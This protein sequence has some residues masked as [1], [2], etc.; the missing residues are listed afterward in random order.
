MARILVYSHDTFG[1]GNIRRMLRISEALVA[2][3]PASSV[4]LVTGSPML[5]AFRLAERIDYV[6]L[7]CLARDTKGEYGVKHLDMDF[8]DAVRMRASVIMAAASEF[9]PDIVL[10][11]KKPLGVAGELAPMLE[12][13][14]RRAD[15][16]RMHLLLRDILD[17]P[18]AT[19]SVWEANDYHGVIDRCYDSILVVGEP[20]I[21]DLAEAYRFP[22]S[23]RCKLHYCGYI[24]R[25][26]AGHTKRP[27]NV[28][29]KMRVLVHAG[30]GQDG[31]ALIEAA[32]GAL[33]QAGAERDYECRVIGGP[34][35]AEVERRRLSVA[36][37]QIADTE[38][39][40]F[41]DNMGAELT[42]ADVVVSMGG[43]NTVCEI[44]SY[45]KRAIVVPRSEPVREQRIRAEGMSRLGLLSMI[46][47][48]DL[49]PAVLRQSIQIELDRSN[50]HSSHAA[51]LKFNGLERICE[52]ALGKRAQEVAQRL[53]QV[54]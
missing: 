10:V 52:L 41:S 16:P 33:V 5:H 7:P 2:H 24:N 39:L 8:G 23:T 53:E 48:E 46:P 29:G 11:D 38:W 4:L 18:Q 3:D 49:S 45:R 28:D 34:E 54:L 25:A 44:L 21:F 47:M 19:R 50:I 32:L 31:V 30:G 22:D 20:Q 9:N 15:R 27:A 42:A 43:Y 12:L 36:A 14:T 13:M 6:K 51:R 37:A 40:D 26:E 17:T 1:L 35:M